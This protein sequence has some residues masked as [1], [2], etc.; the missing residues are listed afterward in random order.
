[1]QLRTLETPQ[2]FLYKGKRLTNPYN[3]HC[4]MWHQTISRRTEPL[5]HY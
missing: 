3:C 1:M 4:R 2:Y 5:E